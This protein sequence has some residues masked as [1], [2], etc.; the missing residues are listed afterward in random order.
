H[1]RLVREADVF[2]QKKRQKFQQQIAVLRAVDPLAI[3]ERG[4]SVTFNIKK[5]TIKSIQQVAANDIISINVN[6]GFIDCRVEE[7]RRNVSHDKL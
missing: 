5:E 2:V 3:M 1:D 7:T 6:D 4:Y